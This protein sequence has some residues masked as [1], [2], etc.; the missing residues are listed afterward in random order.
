MSEES[1]AAIVEMQS[2]ITKMHI[3][4]NEMRIRVNEMRMGAN[5]KSNKVDDES[6]ADAIVRDAGDRTAYLQGQLSALKTACRF[7]IYVVNVSEEWK[8]DIFDTCMETLDSSPT[9]VDP[10]FVKGM[11]DALKTIFQKNESL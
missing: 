10:L 5:E 6:E 3:A 8:T 7:L 9:A 4:I 11:E 2:E 1:L